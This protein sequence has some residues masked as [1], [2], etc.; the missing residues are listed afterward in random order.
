MTVDWTPL[1]VFFLTVTSSINA[2]EL[3]EIHK[4]RI[5]MQSVK[6]NG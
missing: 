6:N 3:R 4:L 2:W 5:E 1:I